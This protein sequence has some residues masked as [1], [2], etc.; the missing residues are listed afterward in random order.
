[1]GGNMRR[2]RP[3]FTFAR[4]LAVAAGGLVLVSVLLAVAPTAAGAEVSATLGGDSQALEAAKSLS[5][6][7]I[8]TGWD[9]SKGVQQQYLTRSE[10]AIMLA[11]ALSLKDS[12][13]PYFTDV[14]SSME[15]FGAV[16]ALYEAGLITGDTATIFN[17][18]GLVSRRRA[19][20]WIMDSLGRKVAEA[21]GTA[22]PF[23]LSY[24]EDAD[25]WLAGFRDRPL[26]GAEYGR[27]VANGYRLGIVDAT[28]DGWFYPTLPVSWGDTAIMLDRA[29]ERSVAPR[30]SYPTA[31]AAV[32]SYPSLKVKSKGALVWFVEYQLT[33]LKYLPG[34]VDGVYDNR[35]RD[36]VMAFQ[37]VEGIKRTGIVGDAVWQHLPGAMTPSPKLTDAGTRVEVDLTKQVL[38][39]ITDN[40]VWKIVH[41]S[42]GRDGTRTGHFHIQ[43]KYKGK[44]RCVTVDG[45][46]YYP[47]YVVS[48]TAIHGY[49]SVPSYP[50]SHGC[51]RVPMWIAEALW[52]DT[53]TGMTIDIYY[54]K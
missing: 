34:A 37:K 5:A 29:F 39:M 17:P 41:V 53:P 52:Y 15:C 27:A 2:F 22:V 4:R 36:A 42:T 51:I 7:G 11:R 28:S 43:E 49:K 45:I 32:W 40:K 21:S 14:T 16:G 48:K 33:S 18:S 50:A 3:P 8:L 26:L 10:L 31:V 46:M 19:V 1:M 44:V 24:F 13:T 47:S 35:T 20:L 25:L 54:N 12:T 6:A 23:R 9:S 30:T 38:F